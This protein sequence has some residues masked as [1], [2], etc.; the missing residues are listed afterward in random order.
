MRH[1]GHDHYTPLDR[2][3]ELDAERV[4]AMVEKRSGMFERDVV[5]MEEERRFYFPKYYLEPSSG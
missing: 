5:A 3:R 1:H 2:G 4:E